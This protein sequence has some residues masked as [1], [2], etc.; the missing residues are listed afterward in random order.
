MD[1]WTDGWMVAWTSQRPGISE[2]GGRGKTPNGMAERAG[3]DIS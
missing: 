3:E 2:Q 1:G